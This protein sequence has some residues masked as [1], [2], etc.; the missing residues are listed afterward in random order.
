MLGSLFKFQSLLAYWTCVAIWWTGYTGW[1]SF[2]YCMSLNS[3]AMDGNL[4][5][6]SSFLLHY[7]SKFLMF[8]ILYLLCINQ[9][10]Y[11]FVVHLQFS[12][13]VTSNVNRSSL[14]YC[15]NVWFFGWLNVN[16]V[17]A[18][19]VRADNSIIPICQRFSVLMNEPEVDAISWSLLLFF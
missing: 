17:I 8:Y 6:L 15:C 19:A 4:A 10:Q 5:M 7:N 12:L 3:S 1:D 9:T 18:I 2:L 11:I 16:T 13:L 14:Y